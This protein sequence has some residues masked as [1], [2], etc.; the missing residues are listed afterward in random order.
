MKTMKFSEYFEYTN[1]NYIFLKITPSTSLRNY[2]SDIFIPIVAKL[3]SKISDRIKNIDNKLIIKANSKLG[4]YIY[5]EKNTVEFYFVVPDKHFNLFKDKIID[6]WSNKVTITTV[7]EIPNF[8]QECSKYYLTYKRTDAMSLICDK[9]NNVLLGSQLNTLHIM[10]EGDKVG[11][12]YNFIPT[13]QETWRATW[14]NAIK[15]MREN[16]PTNHSKISI[17]YVLLLAI[18]LSVKFVDIVLD[19]L[20]FSDLKVEKTKKL[21]DLDLS[22]ATRD[23]R[24]KDIVKSQIVCFSQSE[25]KDRE[26]NNAISLCNSFECLQEDNVLIYKKIKNN[27]VNLLDTVIKGAD[28]FKIQPREGQ[29]FISLPAKEL[30]E[31]YKVI[32]HTKVRKELPPKELLNGIIPLGICTSVN[33]ETIMAY[34]PNTKTQKNLPFA[35]VGANRTGKSSYLANIA[36]YAQKGGECTIFFDFCGNCSISDDIQMVCDNVFTVD[37]SNEKTLQGMGYNEIR[38]DDTNTFRHYDNVKGQASQL[39][40]LVNNIN[41]SDRDLKTKM[42]KFLRAAALIVF[43]NNGSFKDVF[44]ILQE[45]KLRHEYIDRIKPQYL[46]YM[47][48][49][50][51]VL[52]ELDETKVGEVIG[53]KMNPAIYG[54]MDRI[55][56]LQANT[57]MELMFEKD[58]RHNFNLINQMQKAQIICFRMPERMFKTKSEKDTYCTYWMSKIWFALKLRQSYYDEK[59]LVK[60]NIII[61]ELYQ[62]ERCEE[63]VREIL[64]Q[65]PK[66]NARI[67]LS[68]HHINQLTSVK[69]ELLNANGSY[70]LISGCSK[71]NY[72]ALK[73]EMYPYELD[74]IMNLKKFTSLNV[75]KLEDGYYNF[76]TTL[77]K[78]LN[79]KHVL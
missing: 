53:T 27:N 70:I 6:T 10:E 42:N 59:E 21:K 25:N 67:I 73:E 16:I 15:D 19:S 65:L 58:T 33:N 72:Y 48:K 78:P 64:S 43:I 66:F 74:D 44:E 1:P 26:E 14:D 5:M 75:I 13:K 36:H 28:T 71:Q 54:I 2:N 22:K 77:P 4:Y 50:I 23:K 29:N 60:V 46:S 11:V 38:T 18:N 55:D 69:D 57:Y 61:D 20:S 32:S 47:N 31:E 9:R 3:Y 24:D 8:N 17:G 45:H 62:V 30:L 40:A 56:S 79:N 12:F 34:M 49:H 68:C 35:V 39:I 37:C 7:N 51:T 41:D 52:S 63:F 76:V